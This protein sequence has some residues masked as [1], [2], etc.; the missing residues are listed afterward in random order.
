MI[1]ASKCRSNFKDICP[2]SYTRTCEVGASQDENHSFTTL[3]IFPC[4]LQL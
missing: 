1:S 4:Q 2:S 3:A